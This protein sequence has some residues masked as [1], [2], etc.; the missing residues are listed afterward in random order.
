MRVTR[1]RVIHNLPTIHQAIG[2]ATDKLEAKVNCIDA[3]AFKRAIRKKRIKE[4]TVFPGLIQ[5][6]QK[7]IEQV[8]V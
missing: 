3:K 4:D 5:K 7:P 2:G 8:D 6:V 1:H